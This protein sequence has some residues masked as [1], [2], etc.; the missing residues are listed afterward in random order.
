MSEREREREN[1]HLYQYKSNSLHNI[2][3]LL[4]LVIWQVPACLWPAVILPPRPVIS[5]WTETQSPPLC[6]AA[7]GRRPLE[8]SWKT[9][10][11][12]RLLQSLNAVVGNI[13]RAAKRERAVQGN[14][15]TPR[16]ITSLW[17]SIIDTCSIPAPVVDTCSMPCGARVCLWVCFWLSFVFPGAASFLFLIGWSE[18]H[19][20]DRGIKSHTPG[21]LVSLTPSYSS[22]VCAWFGAAWWP[23]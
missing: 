1:H 15:T 3:Q 11:C 2:K 23:H 16:N 13:C 21:N 12:S 19:H 8:D 4:S 17:S 10:D 6:W 22:V 9:T 18:L 20:L 14:R 5:G 7:A